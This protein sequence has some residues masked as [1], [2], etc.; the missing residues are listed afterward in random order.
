VPE[1]PRPRT[2]GLGARHV[3]RVAAEHV[4]QRVSV[5]RW[6]TDPRRGPVQGDAVGR[7]VAWTDE[8]LL[9]IVDREGGGVRVPADDIV[10]SRVVPEHPRLPAEP[11]DA[12]GRERPLREVAV[13]ALLL[14]PQGGVLLR[15][16]RPELPGWH[17]PGVLL[18]RRQEPADAVRTVAAELV[19]DA[20]VS[21]SGAVL[22]RTTLHRAASVWWR[23]EERWH[24]ARLRDQAPHD[25]DAEVA[26]WAIA[27]LRDEVPPTD[28]GD[29]AATLARWW[30]D[31]LPDRAVELGERER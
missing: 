14:D 26:W 8:D 18:G 21:V 3:R 1:G 7:L 13:R 25:E 11:R 28:P 20:E 19:D 12:G 31:G 22:R 2:L 29:L 4:G 17:A 6:I 24:V 5:R 16:P 23:T 15:A 27:R 30:Q 9:V 10:S